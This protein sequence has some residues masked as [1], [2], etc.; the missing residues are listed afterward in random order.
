MRKIWNASYLKTN[1]NTK[2]AEIVNT[3]SPSPASPSLL[4]NFTDYLDEHIFSRDSHFSRIRKQQEEGYDSITALDYPTNFEIN[5]TGSELLST[6]TI[7]DLDSCRLVKKKV[8]MATEHLKCLIEFY[9]NTYDFDG[10]VFVSKTIQKF[11]SIRLHGRVYN[12]AESR[13]E[14][15][16]HV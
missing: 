8:D 13:S 7:A 3:M 11:R 2:L 10:K 5:I 14:K 1:S 6:G 15:G 4:S 12:C 16:T 9:D